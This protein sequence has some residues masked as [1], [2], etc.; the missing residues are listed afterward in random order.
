MGALTSSPNTNSLSAAGVMGG[1]ERIQGTQEL[2]QKQ[3]ALEGLKWEIKRDLGGKFSKD[4]DRLAMLQIAAVINVGIVAYYGNSGADQMALEWLLGICAIL[5]GVE[6][7]V[8]TTLRGCSKTV[9]DKR[10][11]ELQA[12]WRLG[13]AVTFMALMGTLFLVV[14]PAHSVLS[15]QSARTLSAFTVFLLITSNRKFGEMTLAFGRATKSVIPTGVAIFMMVLIYAVA[16]IDLFGNKVEDPSTG[17]PYFDNFSRSL[18]TMFRLFTGN[19]HD[20]M[21]QAAEATTEAA[22]IWFTLYV[23]VI[24]V[25]CCE[26]FVGIVLASYNE[27]QS[28]NSPRMFAALKPALEEC[29]N[30]KRSI[31]VTQLLKLT[32]KMWSCNDFHG[33]VI[34]HIQINKQTAKSPDPVTSSIS[35]V[36][37]ADLDTEGSHSL[38]ETTLEL[39]EGSVPNDWWYSGSAMDLGVWRNHRAAIRAAVEHAAK[40]KAEEAAKEKA[41][42]AEEAAAVIEKAASAATATKAAREATEEAVAAREAEKVAIRETEEAAARVIQNNWRG[43]IGRDTA[44]KAEEAATRAAPPQLRDPDYL[45]IIAAKE[46]AIAWKAAVARKAGEVRIE[47]SKAAVVIQRNWR[48]K[49]GREAARAAEEAAKEDEETAVAA[50]EAEKVA[51]RETEEAAARVIQNNWRGKIGRDTASKAEEAATRAAPP[52]LRDPDYLAIIAA[53]E[54][55]IAWKAAVARKAGEVRIEYSKAA[56]VIQ[57]NWRGKIG[58]EAARAAEEA[59]TRVAPPQLRDPGYLAIIAAKEK[60]IA[61][62]KAAERKAARRKSRTEVKSSF[63]IALQVAEHKAATEATAEMKKIVA[64]EEAA[65]ALEAAEEAAA[66]AEAAGAEAA[67]AT[68]AAQEAEAA[69]KEVAEELGAAAVA[70]KAAANLLK[71]K[72]QRA[73]SLRIAEAGR[74]GREAAAKRVTE[75]AAANEADAEET[76]AAKT[77]IITKRQEELRKQRLDKATQDKTRRAQAIGRFRADKE[78][79]SQRKNA[80]AKKK[81]LILAEMQSLVAYRKANS[82]F[83]KQRKKRLILEGKTYKKKDIS[84][85]NA[86]FEPGFRNR[87]SVSLAPGKI[88]D[89]AFYCIDCN[90]DLDGSR[91]SGFVLSP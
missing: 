3:T 4:D 36:A 68:R 71:L 76:V 14:D 1:A 91:R 67:E 88:V 80:A 54:K 52:Q 44:S 81:E 74:S 51:I 64:A 73:K 31:L 83:E 6:M 89:S 87:S 59:A 16:S 61:W 65:A 63:E 27:V 86:P 49:I 25:F 33:V 11:P 29:T 9:S 38:S 19:W 77:S 41:K 15:A 42:A 47:Y 50:R 35:Q 28:I 43:K 69:A 7:V 39:Y 84:I 45:A 24:S 53:K 32:R 18:A 72:L 13:A 79:A 26:L 34:D 17:N 30:A 8:S 20:V 22:Q 23:F 46:K 62:K 37:P 2:E 85:R 58:R 82:N 66:A 57:R 12:T 56:V 55:A 10:H 60:A 40:E 90:Q 78:E 48:G 70:E 21:F 5:F 75:A